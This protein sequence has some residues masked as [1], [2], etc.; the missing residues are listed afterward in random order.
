MPTRHLDDIRFENQGRAYLDRFDALDLDEKIDRRV[1]ALVLDEYFRQSMADVGREYLSLAGVVNRDN[2]STLWRKT[3]NRLKLMDS[4]EEPGYSAYI[5]QV[6]KFRNMTSHNTDYDPPQSNLEDIRDDAMDWLQWLLDH[7]H[8]YETAHTQTAPRELMIE[9]TKRSLDRM[10]A[11]DNMPEDLGDRLEGL[12]MEA[13]RLHD[14][15]E[16]I[17][18]VENEITVE[19]IDV[20]VETMELAQNFEHLQYME[21]EFWRQ[22]EIEIDE[23]RLQRN[24][25]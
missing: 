10:L 25:E 7:A 21:S 19:L 17:E 12:Q 22:V 9:M 16:A 18:D 1:G 8:Q 20:L 11:E 23:R 14:D 24:E 5:E 13:E 3:L 15:I 4:F 2:V 6:Q